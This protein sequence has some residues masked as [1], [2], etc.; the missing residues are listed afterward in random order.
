M[1]V[2]VTD[3]KAP[4]DSDFELLIQRL[5]NV[6]SDAAL[7]FNCQMGRGR[8]TTG[9][10]IATLVTLR[11]LGAFPAAAVPHFV[12]LQ[13][14]GAT[15]QPQQNGST[16]AAGAS[17]NGCS[18]ATVQ[19]QQVTPGPAVATAQLAGIPAWFAKARVARSSGSGGG[20]GPGSPSTPKSPPT[21]DAKLK[22]GMYG[23]IRS[24]LRVLERGVMGKVI[25]DAVIDAC[26]AMQVGEEVESWQ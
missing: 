12:Q 3:E 5:W 18:Q 13:T 19:P 20:A 15:P 26:S 7:V 9:M 25:L 8:T 16:P 11:R 23:V 24:L 17:S 6:P 4:K 10:V 1:R 2:P 22:S 14:T 21:V